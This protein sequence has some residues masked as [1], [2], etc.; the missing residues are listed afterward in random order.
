MDALTLQIGH[1]FGMK[2]FGCT[3][4]VPHIHLYT[5]SGIAFV[6]LSMGCM[7]EWHMGTTANGFGRSGT[8]GVGACSAT[9]DMNS[10]GPPC[11]ATHLA[12]ALDW[13]A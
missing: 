13:N 5:K 10:G 8:D 1:S 12:P 9:I 7:H 3:I 4:L 2:Q 11:S 6:K